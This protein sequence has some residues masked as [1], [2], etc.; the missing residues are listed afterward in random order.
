MQVNRRRR[1]E[2]NSDGVETGLG[3]LARDE[4]RG[5]PADCSTGVRHKDGVTVDQASV[6]NVGTCRPDAKGEAQVEET[7]RA[8]VPMRGTGA[9]TLVV[10]L[11]VL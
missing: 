1:V 11:K 8:R 10:G 6:R 7:A 5:K 3:L 4:G 2:T 9:E